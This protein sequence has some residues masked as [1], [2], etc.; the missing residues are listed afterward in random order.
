MTIAAERRSCFGYLVLSLWAFSDGSPLLRAKSRHF[1]SEVW[2]QFGKR[3]REILAPQNIYHG[4]FTASMLSIGYG[5]FLL[6]PGDT[7]AV[8][9]RLG[10]GNPLRLAETTWG[11]LFLTAGVSQF[12]GL[13]SDSI[14]WR[15]ANAF[16]MTGLWGA[17]A[18]YYFLILPSS[19]AFFFCSCLSLSSAVGFWMLSEARGTLSK[20]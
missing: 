14:R 13:L 6:L 20:R 16:C 8:H 11:A 1:L 9:V 18:Y 2:K 4:E 15:L 17:P 5:C 19:T 3:L 12:V 10:L 7:F